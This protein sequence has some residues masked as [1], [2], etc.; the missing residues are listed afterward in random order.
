MKNDRSYT[1]PDIGFGLLGLVGGIVGIL[2]GFAA[3]SQSYRIGIVVL[4]VLGSL[5]SIIAGKAWSGLGWFLYAVGLLTG[6]YLGGRW[7]ML[8]GL[9]IAYGISTPLI[10]TY[11]EHM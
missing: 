6:F 9:V 2:A 5:N 10:N 7:G 1:V 8:A 4:F 11:E 3:S